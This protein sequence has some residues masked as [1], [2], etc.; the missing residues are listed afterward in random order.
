MA[1]SNR[2]VMRQGQALVMTPQ[3]LQAIKLLQFSNIELSSFLSDELE[4]NPLLEA[5][6]ADSIPSERSIALEGETRGVGDDAPEAFEGPREGD[7]AGEGLSIDSASLS[8]ELG[9]EISNA[10]EPEGPGVSPSE[11]V[12][13]LEGAGL[14]ATSWNGAAGGG[15]ADGEA[16][17]LE[18]YVA[19]QKGLHE[20]LADQLALCCAGARQRFIGRAIIDAIDETGYLRESVEDIADRLG[21]SAAET[22]AV[23]AIVQTLDP[24][25]VGARDLAE[26][27]AIQLRERDR[28]DPAMEI[29]VANLPLVAKRD[30]AQLSKLCGV[31]EEDILDMAVELRR[32]DPKPGRAFGDPPTQT[33]VADVIVRAA[34]DGSWHVE[35]NSDA[36]PRVLL[37]HTYAAKI[38]AHAKGD[39]DKSFISTC[40]QNANWLLKSLEQRQR[41]ILKVASEIVRLQDAFLAH[42]VEHLRPLNL[43]TIADAI[44]MHES[45]VSRVTSNKYMMTPRGMFELKYFFSASIA[46]TSGAAA[47]SAESVRF[48]IKQMIDRESVDDILS[49]DAI[50]ARL[51]AVD[52]EIARRTVAKYRD[53]LRIPSSVDR[54]REKISAQREHA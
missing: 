31:D 37:N 33:L 18:A 49:D 47:H 3:L 30:F 14:S 43:R 27:L 36:L 17:N 13:A 10:F 40:M 35:L 46:T 6:G 34:G 48:K 7:W 52:I 53:S 51:K 8:A 4:R 29:F 15:G 22:A 32:L 19:A 26:C 2:L 5:D 23:L 50:V 44:G 38:S 16:P 9:T 12:E 24:S 1:I 20:Y 45:T 21:A 54:R 11:P 39:A 28:F 42:G 41:T 25:G